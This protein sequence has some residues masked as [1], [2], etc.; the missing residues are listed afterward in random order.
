M[1]GRSYLWSFASVFLTLSLSV[2]QT[3]D[4]L[5]LFWNL[6]SAVVRG[7]RIL[8]DITEGVGAVSKAI[9]AIDSFLD[10]SPDEKVSKT[11]NETPEI[12][13]NLASISN[14]V[15]QTIGTNTPPVFNGC[16]ALGFHIR[17]EN[18]PVTKMTGCCT[19]HDKCYSSSCKSNKRECDSALATCLFSMCDNN[20]N[21][22]PD[23]TFQKS[24]KSAAKLLFSGTM[25]LSFQQYNEAQSRLNCKFQE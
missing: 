9:H 21:K 3:S 24:C 19:E 16:G 22:T 13:T 25:A 5:E 10:I 11:E 8:H 12:K 14:E 20:N 23:K 17:D 4:N 1:F 18:L 2:G 7:S 15:T 6:Y